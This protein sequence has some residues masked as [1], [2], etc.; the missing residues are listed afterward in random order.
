MAGQLSKLGLENNNASYVLSP[1][2]Y[3][4]LLVEAP[5]VEAN[6]IADAVKW[7]IKDLLKS[8]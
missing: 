1:D 6:E 7:K 4:I 2:E 3:K 5:D 8:C